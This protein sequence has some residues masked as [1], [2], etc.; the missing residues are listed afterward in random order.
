MPEH[1]ILASGSQARRELLRNAG[2]AFDAEPARVDER[3]IENGLPA[4]MR[5]PQCI[6]EQLAIAKARDVSVRH[7][8]TIVIGCD[9]TMS[10]GDQLFHKAPDRAQAYATLKTLCGQ[11]HH[12]NSAVCLVRDGDVLW[13][14]VGVARMSM[15]DFTPSF[16]D[17]YLDRNLVRI[18][19][20]VGCY[21]LEGE[22]IQLF[23]AVDGDYFTILGLPI[24]PLL[25]ALRTLGIN[26]A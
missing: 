5:T 25:A 3:A 20:S 4:E 26:H 8:G 7:P 15:R 11:T 16:L 14:H 17:Q 22:G 2:L 18:L 1:L 21:Q 13:S 24:L 12:L 23:D 10:L 9:Q 19:G 6:A